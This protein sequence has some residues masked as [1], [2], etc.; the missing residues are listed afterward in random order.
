M[1]NLIRNEWMKLWHKKATWIMAILLVVILIGITG[2]VKFAG[3]AIGQMDGLPW[4]ERVAEQQANLTAQLENPNLDAKA[5]KQVEEDLAVAEYRLA[6]DIAPFEMDTREQNIMDSHSFLS[7]VLMFAVIAAASIVASEFS[8]GTIKMLL[9]RPVKRWKILTSKYLTTLLYALVLTIIAFVS[10]IIAGYLFFDAGNGAMLDV[11]GGEVV[12]ASYWG[13]VLALYG[14]QFIGVVVFTT[15]A[16]MLGSVFRTSSLAIGLSIF[17]LFTG[18]TM[19]YFLSKY[20]IVK[21]ILFTH[22]DMTGY[23]TGNVF[24]PGLTWPLSVAVLT[25]YVVLFLFISYWT[26]TKRDITA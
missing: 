22:T 17:L 14:L 3:S 5:R 10:N 25:V 20:E 18:P 23:L 11:R 21:Y 24:I 12:E 2:I 9:S 13:R 15:F 16:F 4:E 7:L 6:N 1:L 26:F 19:V 8:Q